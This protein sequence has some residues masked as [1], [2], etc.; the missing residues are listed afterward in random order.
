MEKNFEEVYK[1]DVS[2]KVEKKGNLNYLSWAC[3]WAEFKK[4]YPNAKYAIKR[5][6]NNLPYVHDVNT[7]YMVFTEVTVDDLTH[8]MWL[9]VMDNRNNALIQPSMTEINKA[10]MRCL[11]KNLAMFGLGLYIYEGE[12]L[13]EGDPTPLDEALVKEFEELGGT[14]D[15]AAKYYKT[16]EDKLTNEQLKQLIDTQK[17]NIAKAQNA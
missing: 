9:P 17:E 5:F 2:N 11:T 6:E 3:A 10:I 16:T 15:R 4:I 12:D 14:L 7:G 8:E 13:P 1:I